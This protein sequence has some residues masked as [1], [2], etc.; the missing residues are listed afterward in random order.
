MIPIFK[1]LKNLIV[2]N[3]GKAIY[4]GIKK[5]IKFPDYFPIIQRF[6]V[7]DNIIYVLTFNRE[8]NKSEFFLFNMKGEFLKKLM[9]PFAVK[10]PVGFYPY[11]I[12]NGK[13]YQLIEN[14][15]TD[16]WELH[17]EEIK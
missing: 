12:N 5:W 13:L 4:G 10:D 7:S 16:L 3:S 1:K 6:N 14:E 8:E 17:L 2:I 9:V 11:Y 15:E